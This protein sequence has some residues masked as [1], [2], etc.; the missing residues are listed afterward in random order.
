MSRSLYI[1][2][3]SN[4]DVEQ[5]SYR[6]PGAR[7][8]GAGILKDWRLMFKSAYATVE[9]Q[10]GFNTP[11]LIWEINKQHEIGL[12]RYEGF[13][14]FYYKKIVPIDDFIKYD[15]TDISTDYGMIYIMDETHHFYPPAASYFD[16]LEEAYK[17]FNFDLHILTE[18]LC[19]SVSMMQLSTVSATPT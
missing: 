1:A 6:C 5:M 14:H 8:I 12:D 9:K 4:M 16:V 17:K 19:Y 15:N 13:P 7:L 11:I 3:G 10:K 18:A 2:Y